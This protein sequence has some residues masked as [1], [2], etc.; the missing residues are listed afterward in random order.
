MCLKTR[1]F[2]H[3]SLQASGNDKFFGNDDIV[4]NEL[5]LTDFETWKDLDFKNGVII[6]GYAHKKLRITYKPDS[7]G[8]ID[9]QLFVENMNNSYHNSEKINVH[10]SVFNQGVEF[11]H[12]LRVSAVGMMGVLEEIDT[13][14]FGNCFIGKRTFKVIQIHNPTGMEA[15]CVLNGQHS[16]RKEI[17]FYVVTEQAKGR[18]QRLG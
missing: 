10:A 16:M 18:D 14:D 15:T 7:T 3:F 1:R 8:N 13:L 4:T 2:S 12:S 5:Q 11:E 9:Y 6:S 17:S